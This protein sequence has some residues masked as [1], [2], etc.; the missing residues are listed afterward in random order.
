MCDFAKWSTKILSEEKLK[1]LVMKL[2]Q[3]WEKC[4]LE[5]L[6]NLKGKFTHKLFF[7]PFVLKVEDILIGSIYVT[8]AV[9]PMVG[10]SLKEKLESTNM[11]EFCKEHG[12]TSITVD[13]EECKYSAVKEYSAYL[14]DLYSRMLGKKLASFKLVEG[15]ISRRRLSYSM[16]EGDRQFTDGEQFASRITQESLISIE[17]VAGVGKTTFSEQFCYKWSQGKHLNDCKLLLFLPLRDNGVRS[18]RSVSDLFQHPQLQ[19]AIAEEVE[20]SGGEGVVLWLDGWDE[21][22]VQ[23]RNE[24]AF[25]HGRVLPKATV[26]I[27]SRPREH[28]SDTRNF[29]A[30]K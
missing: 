29:R 3:R 20:S 4:T 19:Q 13:G 8:R 11:G 14:K 27:T 21:L 22:E 24:S 26:I 25:L 1:L 28:T 5:D 17:G 30:L 16:Y 10:A 9:P 23:M 2:D 15:G 12:I 18:V 6:E 7:S